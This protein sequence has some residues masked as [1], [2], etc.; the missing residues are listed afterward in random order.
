MCGT[1]GHGGGDAK[2]DS[3][4]RLQGR[5]CKAQTILWDG[6]VGVWF[7]LNVRGLSS[8]EHFQSSP[9]SLPQPPRDAPTP[10]PLVSPVRAVKSGAIFPD[11][12][13]ASCFCRANF[14]RKTLHPIQSNV[15]RLFLTTQASH[16]VNVPLYTEL[17]SFRLR[18]SMFLFSKN[19]M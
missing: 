19:I 18:G 13:N 15:L 7:C 6:A 12:G 1:R 5:P 11:L 2:A 8:G 16:D 4:W 3:M 10:R 17:S 14:A 9:S